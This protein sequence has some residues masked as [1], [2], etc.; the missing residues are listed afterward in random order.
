MLLFLP[1]FYYSLDIQKS[2][3]LAKLL[4]LVNYSYRHDILP[5]VSVFSSVFE[6]NKSL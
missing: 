6:Y 2:N 3:L 4:F 5:L 1:A